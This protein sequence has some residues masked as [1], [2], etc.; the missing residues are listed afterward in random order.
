MPTRLCVG[1]GD[2][3]G[4]VRAL[5]RAGDHRHDLAAVLGRDLEAAKVGV[6]LAAPLHE[7]GRA[8]PRRAHGCSGCDGNVPL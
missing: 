1:V 5:P 4:P 7:G 2:L 3:C 6:V 8:R